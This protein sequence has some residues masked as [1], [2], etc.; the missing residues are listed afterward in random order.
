MLFYFIIASRDIF[1]LPSDHQDN[2]CKMFDIDIF[3]I[4]NLRCKLPQ[5]LK[6]ICNKKLNEIFG[7]FYLIWVV[8]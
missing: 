3:A 2:D 5:K 8:L 7:K 1:L 4:F 6:A